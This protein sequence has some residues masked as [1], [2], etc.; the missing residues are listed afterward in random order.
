[1]RGRIQPNSWKTLHE[2]LRIDADHAA[3]DVVKIRIGDGGHHAAP[4]LLG[5][6]I[7]DPPYGKEILQMPRKARRTMLRLRR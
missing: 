6:I 7:L 4:C 5:Q 1:M 3:Y 2:M